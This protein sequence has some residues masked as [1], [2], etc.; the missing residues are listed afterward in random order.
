[1][2]TRSGILSENNPFSKISKCLVKFNVSSVWFSAEFEDLLV[3]VPFV[4][5]FSSLL[6]Q[7]PFVKI[8]K[9]VGDLEFFCPF[10]FR[11]EQENK[12]LSCKYM[13]GTYLKYFEEVKFW[14]STFSLDDSWSF[15]YQKFFCAS[16]KNRER[17]WNL[18]RHFFNSRRIFTLIRVNNRLF[19]K[20]PQNN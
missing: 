19:R 20:K 13:L 1:M 15:F 11:Y 8:F 10:N 3:T 2:W 5:L 16:T 7:W 12:I 6:L 17:S 4:I 14:R 18:I 9:G